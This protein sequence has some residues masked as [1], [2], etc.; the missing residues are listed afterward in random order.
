[1]AEEQISGSDAALAILKS[2]IPTIASGSIKH[3][4]TP[5]YLFWSEKLLAKTAALSS[6]VIGPQGSSAACEEDTEFC[7]KAFRLWASHAE[8]KRTDPLTAAPST[9][10]RGIESIAATWKAYYDVLTAVLQKRLPY[11]PPYDGPPAKQLSAEFKRV[12]SITEII[13]LANTKFPKANEGN[14]Y[15]ET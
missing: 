13:F 3:A 14:G 7:L 15:V 2:I 10:A 4:S 12:Q 6:R 1:S 11:I 9:H 8:V 5:Q